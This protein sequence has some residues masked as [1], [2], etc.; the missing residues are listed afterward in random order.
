M[1]G[2]VS[3]YGDER[4]V[5]FL[6]NGRLCVIVR[7]HETVYTFEKDGR[8]TAPQ[9]VPFS[10]GNDM[11]DSTAGP[12]GK[13]LY[14]MTSRPISPEDLSETHHLWTTEWKGTSWA[15]PRPLPGPEKIPGNGS[16]YP[17]ATADGTVYFISDARNGY[18]EGGIYRSRNTDGEHQ[19]AELVERPINSTYI[20]FDPCVAPD[21]SYLVFNS[22]RPGGFGSWDTYI[23]L[24]Q[25]DGGWTPPINL[26]PGFNS[27]ASEA[28]PT[29][30]SDG[31]YLFFASRRQTS[32]LKGKAGTPPT[33]DRDSYWVDTSFIEELKSRY[34]DTK[35]STERVMEEY[36]KNGVAA[37]IERLTDLY[38]HHRAAYS[39]LP[40]DLLRACEEMISVGRVEDADRFFRAMV[41][42][43]PE[44]GRIKLGYALISSLNGY[45]DNGLAI[46][47]EIEGIDQ[48]L[49]FE[50]VVLYLGHMLTD[51]SQHAGARIF[52]EFNTRKYPDSFRSFYY[53]AVT[54][55]NL[56]DI[57]RA[58]KN[59]RR[60]QELNP[61]NPAISELMAELETQQ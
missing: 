46:V 61:D 7:D 54:S 18:S 38:T 50:N 52:F 5:C 21:E 29:I 11:P 45:A 16:G 14:F 15:T 6:D 25:G 30:S 26:G 36:R 24:R 42:V 59:C 8:W 55:K 47:Q 58:T 1:P 28:C 33:R 19:P 60:A 39:F 22:N 56:G 53:L 4:T 35:S 23:C 37:T 32:A 2:L 31:R 27:S 57:E 40:N 20:D 44:T 13:T 17:T 34:Q 48:T 10:Y 3:T 43:L 41:Q 12:D 9:V 51:A 49:N